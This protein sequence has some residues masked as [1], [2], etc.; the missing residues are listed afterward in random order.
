MFEPSTHCELRLPLVAMNLSLVRLQAKKSAMLRS[1]VRGTPPPHSPFT[2][3][4]VY[5]IKKLHDC[6]CYSWQSKPITIYSRTPTSAVQRRRVGRPEWAAQFSDTE[7]VQWVRLPVTCIRRGLQSTRRTRK[8]RT[9]ERRKERTCSDE[10]PIW[11]RHFIASV[12]RKITKR[13]K[14]ESVGIQ[15]SPVGKTVLWTPKRRVGERNRSI[16]PIILNLG[17]RWKAVVRFTPRPL[18]PRSKSS[19]CPF[20]IKLEGAHR[21]SAAFEKRKIPAFTAN[22]TTSVHS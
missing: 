7:Q 12:N 18:H 8:S 21:G 14:A 10:T 16:R 5:W 4:V 19:C 6:A 22:H 11:N 9:K 2:F 1:H 20:S 15:R 3:I 17:T 13:H